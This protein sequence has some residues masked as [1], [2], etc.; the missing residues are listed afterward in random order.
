MNSE[1]M[2]HINNKS[3]KENQNSMGMKQ[4]INKSNTVEHHNIIKRKAASKKGH[5]L[6]FNQTMNMNVNSINQNKFELSPMAKKVI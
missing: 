6:S 3:V 5:T 1:R 4:S 2:D